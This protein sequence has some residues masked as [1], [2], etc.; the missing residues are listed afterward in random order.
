[1]KVFL[2]G[3]CAESTW[4]EEVME[5]LSLPYFNPVVEDWTPACQ[6]EETRQKEHEC[7][8]HLYVIT[9]EMQGVFSIAEA[10]ESALLKQCVFQVLPEGFTEPQLRSLQATCDL[11][12]RNGA[13]AFVCSDLQKC[14]R[15]LNRMLIC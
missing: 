10:V 9:S 13:S 8:I 3:T 14:V 1:M 15:I 6:A 5:T 11:L 4:R 7:Q 2:G 12:V